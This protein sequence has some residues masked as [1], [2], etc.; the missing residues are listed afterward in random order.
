MDAGALH[1]VMF[2]KLEQV[3]T[4]FTLIH[5]TFQLTQILTATF[6]PVLCGLQLLP[7]ILNFSKAVLQLLFEVLLDQ[8][9][10]Y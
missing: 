5:S 10:A 4:V 8:D 1:K 7:D 2:N 9:L 3:F 6:A